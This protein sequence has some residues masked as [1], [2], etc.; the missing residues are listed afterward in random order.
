VWLSLN[1]VRPAPL[2]WSDRYDH[3]REVTRDD[4]LA[5]MK[6]VDGRHRHDQLVALRSLFTWAKLQGLI[7]RDPSSWIRVGQIPRRS[8][9][10]RRGPDRWRRR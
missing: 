9:R 6:S 1:Q 8:A 10:P 3:L 2:R 4:I 5:H 7:F